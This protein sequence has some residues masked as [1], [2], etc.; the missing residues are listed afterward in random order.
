MDEVFK[1]SQND[2]ENIPVALIIN[3]DLKFPNLHTNSNDISYI[4]QKLKAHKNDAFC[5]LPFCTTVEAQAMGANINLGDEKNCPRVGN[6]AFD[7]IKDLLKISK[8]DLNKGRIK[9]VLDAISMLKNKDEKVVLNVC[10]PFTII[11]LLIDQKYFYKALRKDKSTIDNILK[12][13]EDNIVDYAV[14]ANENG[15]NIISFSDPVASIEIVGPRVYKE[16]VGNT[17]S[18]LLNKLD[19]A[20][21]DTIIHLCGKTSTSLEFYGFCESEK[22][23][24]SK[25][26]MYGQAIC[27]LISTKDKG[28]IFIGHNCMKRTPYKT[29]E[30]LLYNIKIH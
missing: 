4:S 15:V 7:D 23:Y 9:E 29:T 3:T 16:I 8:I 10:G 12:I 17:I 11:S 1:C 18:R 13:I 19:D 22:V 14:N 30:S 20:L 24:Y 5:K 25:D 2:N 21:D 26:I 28:N 6:Y 27:E